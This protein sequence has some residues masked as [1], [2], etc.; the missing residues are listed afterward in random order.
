MRAIRL[1][2]F[3]LVLGWLTVETCQAF[4]N[5]STGRWLNRDPIAEK[6]GLNLYGFVGNDSLDEID[7]LGLVR[8]VFKQIIGTPRV[9][10]NMDELTQPSGNGTSTFSQSGSSATSSLVV[11]YNGGPG[12]YCCNS[13]DSSIKKS[14]GK[15][16]HQDS[17]SMVLYMTDAAAGTYTVDITASVSASAM[18][19]PGASYGPGAN[20]KVGGHSGKP[21]IHGGANPKRPFGETKSFSVTVTVSSPSDMAYVAEYI[22]T[23]GIRCCGTVATVGTIS[24][25]GYTDP[26]GKKVPTPPVPNPYE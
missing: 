5:P 24:V 2:L 4:Y 6:G 3:T 16:P 21:Q 19:C 12:E 22:T 20:V 13:V 17:A 1:M 11:S 9:I 23:I 15:T 26:S 14:D 7:I 25:T 10:G 18:E 8:F